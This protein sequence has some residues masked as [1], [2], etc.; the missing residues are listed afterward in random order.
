MSKTIA[1]LRDHLFA[2]LEGLT[3]KKH[4]MDIDRAVAIA[5]VA[6]VIINSA[7]VEVEAIRVA[8][9]KGSGFFPAL[10]APGASSPAP[11]KPAPD[12]GGT[13]VIAQR[14]GVRVLQHKLKG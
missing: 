10:A 5:D 7:K 14:P 11:E 4:P 8:G 2:A 12:E 1:D 3:D 6:Q 9:G 13:T